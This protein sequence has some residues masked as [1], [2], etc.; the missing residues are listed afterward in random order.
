MCLETH[1]EGRIVILTGVKVYKGVIKMGGITVS[2]LASSGAI[3]AA[4][5]VASCT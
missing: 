5:A 1:S 2:F 3:P 4:L